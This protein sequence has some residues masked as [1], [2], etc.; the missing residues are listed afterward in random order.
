MPHNISNINNT[1]HNNNLNKTMFDEQPGYETRVSQVKKY[2][3]V[4]SLMILKLTQ[5]LNL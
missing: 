2:C 1:A 3:K 4:L 5:I